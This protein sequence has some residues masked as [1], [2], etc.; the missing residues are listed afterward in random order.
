MALDVQRTRDL[1]TD[2]AFHR[3]FIEELGWSNPTSGKKPVSV[4]VADQSIERTAIAE[5]AG[6]MVFEI[7]VA[8]GLIPDAKT[9]RAIH[10]A[11]ASLYHEN[12]LIF[13]D[14]PRSQSLWYWVKR[15]DTRSQAREHLYVKGQPGDLFL[16]KLQSMVVDLTEFDAGVPSVVEVVQRLRTALDVE[17]VTRKF[18]D[19]FKEQH[20]VFLGLISG[21]TKEADRRWYASV[22]L[23]RLMFVYF[24]QRKGFIDNDYWYLQNKLAES[25]SRG[26]DRFY[27]EFLR[28][29]F[30]QGFAKPE[31]ERS[32]MVRSLVGD[33]RYLNG[34]LF[35][36]HKIEL[37]YTNIA[38]PDH[39]F[40]N[41]LAL[42]QRY[43][44]NLN[45]A[46]G[47]KDD[48]I[49][50][51]VLGY[52]FEKYI[53]Q[54]DFGAYYTRPEM[55]EYLCERTIHKLILDRI[56]VPVIPG[57][58][59]IRRF[60]DINE[61]LVRLDADLCRRLLHDI[62]PTL[63]IL[64]PACGSGA[65]LVAAMKTLINIY[66]AV[67]GK[68][69]FLGDRNLTKWLRDAEHEH[70]SLAYFIK[71][72]IITDNLYG[73]DLMEEG[74]EIAKLRL[75]L[76]LVSSA[77]YVTELEP[78]PNID[79]NILAGNA[80]VGLLHVDP[81][82]A[83]L[84]WGAEQYRRIL[85]EKN[86]LVD[87]YRH[88]ATYAEDL[89]ALREGID[90]RKSEDR[91]KLDDILLQDFL[92]LGVKYEQATLRG[93]T[94][95]RTLTEKDIAALEPLH[96]GYEFDEIVQ[97]QGGFDIIITNPPWDIFKPQA[98]EF[99][100]QYSDLVTKKKMDIKAFETHQADLL[101]DPEIASAWLDYQSRY[102]YVSA[103]YRAAE[104]YKNQ[105]SIVNGKKAGTDINLYKLFV[106]QCYNLLKEGGQCGIVI[107]SGIY[108]DLGAK[109]LREMLF[110][111]TEVTGLFGFENR[112]EIF[113]GVHRSYKF[114]VLTFERGGSTTQFPAA[115]MRLDVQE[116]EHFPE[117][118]SIP[119]SVELIRRL[120]PDSLSLLEF[121]S[122]MDVR[123]AEK[124]LEYPLLGEKLDGKWN[125]RLN[126]EFDMTNDSSLFRTAPRRGCLPL[127][128]GK[129]IH[130][131]THLFAEPRYWVDEKEGRQA[132]LGHASDQGQELGYQRYRVG[133]RSSGEN[134]NIRN[135]ISA[136]I[137][138]QVFC[139]NSIILSEGINDNNRLLLVLCSVFNSFVLDYA[140]RLKIS[141]NMNMFYIYQL[142]VPRLSEQDAVFKAIEERAAKLVCT[143]PEF[144]ELAADVGLGSHEQGVTNPT[145]RDKLRSELDGIVAHLYGL[146]EEEFAHI[147]ATF[148]IV[149]EPIK[150]AALDAFRSLA[151]KAG[152]PEIR[153]LIAQGESATLELKSSAR[154]DMKE[155]RRNKEMEKV[156]VKTVVGFLNTDG[157]TLLIG[158][159]DDGTVLGLDHDYQTLGERKNRDGY[160]QA[161]TQLLFDAYG[162][163]KSPYIR[164][165]FHETEGK[166]V[167]RITVKPSPAPI[168]VNIDGTER[169]Y[170]RTNNSSRALSAREA[171]EYVREHWK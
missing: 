86:R 104:Q 56:N 131:F 5:L 51:D 10:H 24:L 165:S 11:I 81:S 33:V 72:R 70:R 116:L 136:V 8:D 4:E 142:P 130:Q 19:E 37:A 12:L 91:V 35:L 43:S 27:G 58:A 18:Y 69:T 50:P 41:I 162:Y 119:I 90:A 7:T 60:N 143:T 123:I 3:L 99:F 30:F 129:M 67:I 57:T 85:E 68:I 80:L 26:S 32:E 94:T 161:L 100:R 169:L 154:W 96:W 39:A 15:E 126:R 38:I 135:F 151:P 95:K 36:P 144:D 42:F 46:P 105:I 153:K 88:A 171:V 82:K 117:N 137:P 164:I 140:I 145:E 29:L 49:S 63:S 14:R 34:G 160:E 13:V 48:E 98:K 114:G 118:G 47:G 111:H 74:T 148:P 84:F 133:F 71:K 66:S 113:E 134:T 45:D 79:F 121:K 62:L 132:L 59:T 168:W 52:I 65:F 54:K 157:G 23:N 106:E 21:I 16:T 128:E 22:M 127:Y 93:K 167:C 110:K 159:A 20:I 40:D 92:D 1:L 122:E 115:F 125:L 141:R 138:K 25:K 75:F 77:Q 120:S 44:W 73:V 61:L 89:Q 158:V 64:D 87:N 149:T 155:K 152:D 17:R 139:G 97:S 146:T 108:T 76:A 103:Y 9:R 163:D 28:A 31:G 55:T 109:Q 83:N 53:N 124:M 156:I 102:P 2:F 147:L 166:D 101:K 6:V 78:L 112:K 150:V 170:I 107:P